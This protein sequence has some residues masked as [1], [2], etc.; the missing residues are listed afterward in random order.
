MS[1]SSKTGVSV[2]RLESWSPHIT[3]RIYRNSYVN[4]F[5]SSHLH[6][7]MCLLFGLRVFAATCALWPAI[8]NELESAFDCRH[9]GDVLFCVLYSTES[10]VI[11]TYRECV[12]A[13]AT[14]FYFHSS[15]GLNFYWS[16]AF[17]FRP[18]TNSSSCSK[19][20]EP[21]NKLRDIVQF[22]FINHCQVIHMLHQRRVV[23]SPM[24]TAFVWHSY[25][26]DCVLCS[27]RRPEISRRRY[28]LMNRMMIHCYDSV[29]FCSNFGSWM[30]SEA[31]A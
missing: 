18:C 24:A 12:A 19:P 30:Y 26:V 4:S 7:Y 10:Y 1:A 17:A 20:T 14:S 13:H 11:V 6:I 3:L 5:R 25:A 21:T 31:V 15:C 16:S 2:E 22:H 23:V 8:E 9:I 27:D 29:W 28:K